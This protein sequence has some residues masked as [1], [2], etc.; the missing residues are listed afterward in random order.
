RTVARPSRRIIGPRRIGLWRG[1]ARIAASVVILRLL[2][3]LRVID[4]PAA[5]RRIGPVRAAV[6]RIDVIGIGLL[7]RQHAGIAGGIVLRNVAAR[8]GGIGA[9]AGIARERDLG[10]AGQHHGGL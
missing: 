10:G 4:A 1:L 5:R 2:I 7:R 8:D 9:V 3:D 6:G